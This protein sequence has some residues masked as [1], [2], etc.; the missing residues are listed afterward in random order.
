ML[1]HDHHRFYPSQQQREGIG[2]WLNGRY[3]VGDLSGANC[4]W[5][6]SGALDGG[7]SGEADNWSRGYTVEEMSGR[8]DARSSWY[9]VE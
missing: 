7:V 5:S 2:L 6:L 3:V 4:S 8:L 9:P 1:R